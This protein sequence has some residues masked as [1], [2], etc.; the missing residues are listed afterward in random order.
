MVSSSDHKRLSRL[1]SVFVSAVGAISA[2]LV[3]AFWLFGDELKGLIV[4]AWKSADMWHLV[5]FFSMVC[6]ASGMTASLWRHIIRSEQIQQL[7]RTNAQLLQRLDTDQKSGLSSYEFFRTKFEQEYLP[8]ASAGSV[9]SV[10]MIDVMNFKG[11][12]DRFGHDM[13]DT[14]ISFFGGFLKSFVRGRRDM[15]AR[16]GQAA[17]E[18]FFVISG[19]ESALSGFAN[20][21]RR[22]LGEE[23]VPNLTGDT[24]DPIAL[25]FWATG[26]LVE[27]DDTWDRIQRR[28]NEGMVSVKSDRRTD[29]VIVR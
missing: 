16:H 29:I 9:F 6:F 8:D 26:T 25:G 20:R 2:T 23:Q 19:D 4:S 22:E 24:G 5:L 27:R 14:V 21:L 28:L 11:I 12:N 15:A 7:E 10:L 1:K 13:G 17:D 3:A 18:F